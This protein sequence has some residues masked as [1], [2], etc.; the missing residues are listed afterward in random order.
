METSF[1]VALGKQKRE[2]QRQKEEAVAIAREEEK[3][4]AEHA[5]AAAVA[6]AREEE[7][8]KA[9]AAHKEDGQRAIA[10]APRFSI[11]FSSSAQLFWRTWRPWKTQLV[12]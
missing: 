8:Q 4:N 6:A 7:Q 11:L 9:A 12:V 1:S 5:V 2:L 3:R 10:D